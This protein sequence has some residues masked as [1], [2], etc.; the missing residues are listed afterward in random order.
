MY[1]SN[2]GKD[3]TEDTWY[4]EHIQLPSTSNF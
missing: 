1:H 4:V 3:F 2:F